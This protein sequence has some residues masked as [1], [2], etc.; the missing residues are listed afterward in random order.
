VPVAA[1]CCIEGF[2]KMEVTCSGSLTACL[3]GV[4]IA[5]VW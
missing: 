5:E 2:H 3:D 1:D 4:V